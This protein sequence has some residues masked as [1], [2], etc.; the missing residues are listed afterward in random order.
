MKEFKGKY[1]KT[2]NGKFWSIISNE[3]GDV[4]SFWGNI[5]TIEILMEDFKN[6]GVPEE[7]I[8]EIK[9]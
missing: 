5:E 3:Q 6:F 8:E 9:G 1:G 4:L 7:N 2:P